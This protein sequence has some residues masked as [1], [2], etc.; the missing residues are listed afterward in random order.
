MRVV[1]LWLSSS[2]PVG[3]TGHAGGVVERSELGEGA[4]GMEGAEFVRSEAAWHH[5]RFAASAFSGTV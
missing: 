2:V 1:P 5:S 4:V 3:V